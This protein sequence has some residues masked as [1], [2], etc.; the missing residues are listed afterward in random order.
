[1]QNNLWNL[2][3][4]NII[5]TALQYMEQKATVDA[6][7]ALAFGVFTHVSPKPPLVGGLRLKKS[8][9]E[10]LENITG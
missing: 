2:G 1:V 10:D 3:A 5:I 8:L 9:T 4:L 7:F 6:I